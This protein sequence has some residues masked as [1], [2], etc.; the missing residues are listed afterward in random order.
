MSGPSAVPEMAP[1][2]PPHNPEQLCTAG[3]AAARVMWKLKLRTQPEAAQLA[4]W[5][6]QLAV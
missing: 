3:A 6:Y 1:Q 2:S 5:P 4:S